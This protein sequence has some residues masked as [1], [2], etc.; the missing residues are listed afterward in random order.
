MVHKTSKPRNNFVAISGIVEKEG[1]D[2]CDAILGFLAFTGS[3]STSAFV[4]RGKKKGL[5]LIRSNADHLATMKKLGRSFHFS[6]ELNATY[7]RFVCCLYGQ[8]GSSIDEARFR[9]FCCKLQQIL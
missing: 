2:V 5:D 9:L 3:D 8:N 1:S 6:N 4:G 7:E